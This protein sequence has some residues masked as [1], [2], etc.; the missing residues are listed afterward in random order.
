MNETIKAHILVTIATLLIASSFLV[1]GKLSGI[2]DPISIT[3]Y[4]FV[5]ATLILSPIFIKKEYRAKFLS[6][7]KRGLIISFF[8]SIY[9]IGMFKALESTTVLNTSTLY[10]L[11]PLMT[12]VLCILFFKEKIK[13]NQL[14][15]YCIAM[16]G[17]LI[18]IFKA[19]L[20]SFLH[21]SLN[22]GDLIFIIACVSM[23]LYSIFL[24]LLHKEGDVLLVLV[25]STL[26]GG[27]IWMFLAM[28]F[29]SVPFE[30]GKIEGNLLYLMLYLSIV[31]T[32]VTLFLYQKA[33]IILGSKKLMAYTYLS[34]AMVA[35]LVY[36]FDN[37]T[38]TFG[39]MIGI[40]L[41]TIATIIILRQK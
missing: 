16:I 10:T 34:P 32:V 7:I 38:I 14:V 22:Q 18:V 26:L 5:I 4:R 37:Q 19:N 35:F 41:S 36:I 28:Q 39:V 17:T 3:M 12:A 1:S 40:L 30:W 23:A 2:I 24:K 15:I 11:V 31:T 21:F 6:T 33:S 13:F 27:I 25:F 8:Y 20:S 9:F 29:L